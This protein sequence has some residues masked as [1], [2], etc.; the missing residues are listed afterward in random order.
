MKNLK[1]LIL[2]T[3]CLL[4]SSCGYIIEK[5]T[6]K[7]AQRLSDTVLNYEDP[8]TISAAMPTFLILIDSIANHKGA[9]A[10]S[11]LSAAQLYG[12]YSGAFVT[13][14]NRQKILTTKA[15]TYAQ[16]GSC[17]KDKFWCNLDKLDK[18]QFSEF[19]EQLDKKDV[20]LTYAYAVAWLGYIQSHGDDWNVIADLS[21]AQL[22]LESVIKFD[23]AYDNAGAHLYLAAIASSLP[24][25]LGGKPDIGKHHFERAIEITNGRHLLIKVEYARR[26]ARLL[27]DK[28][29]HHQLLTDVLNAE[30][31]QNGLT[32]MNTWA[33]QEAQKLLADESNYFD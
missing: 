1:I 25:A 26:Y 14:I 27:F 31:K 18:K 10:N 4:G 20:D 9:G 17:Q 13:D 21:K 8:A 5:Q 15:L 33:Q 32:L 24:P 19:I 7:A 16:L 6:D 11:Q 29:L 28:E 2:I 12:A 3:S 23:E 30:P 22:L